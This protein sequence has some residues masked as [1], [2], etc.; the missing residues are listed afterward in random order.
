MSDEDMV[1]GLYMVQQLMVDV[2]P[3]ST[4]F[5][6]EV[7]PIPPDDEPEPELLPQIISSSSIQEEGMGSDG[8]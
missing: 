5:W 4:T 6:C 8:R 2:Q 3:G 7:S 1:A